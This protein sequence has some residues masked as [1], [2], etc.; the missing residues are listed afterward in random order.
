MAADSEMAREIKRTG[1]ILGADSVR[2]SSKGVEDCL[3]TA[4]KICVEGRSF[5]NT[6]IGGETAEL[7]TLKL[8]EVLLTGVL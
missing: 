7:I 1:R 5:K 4:V 2:F 6:C 3:F 8:L